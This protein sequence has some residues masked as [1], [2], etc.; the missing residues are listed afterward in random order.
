M[1]HQVEEQQNATNTDMK[2]DSHNDPEI[3]AGKGRDKSEDDDEY[4][5]K[6]QEKENTDK[7]G[8]KKE[9]STTSG[10]SNRLMGP[11]RKEFK[12]MKKMLSRNLKALEDLKKKMEEDPSNLSTG[13]EDLKQL[14]TGD[15]TLKLERLEIDFESDSEYEDD[16]ENLK[17]LMVF[18]NSTYEIVKKS[19]GKA[20]GSIN[21]PP[22]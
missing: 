9:S 2:N 10:S 4:R 5:R 16:L 6:P 7:N 12:L 15:L 8:R 13:S 18:N 21:N 1:E 22:I 3:V 11:G 17:D 14:R 20:A 19:L